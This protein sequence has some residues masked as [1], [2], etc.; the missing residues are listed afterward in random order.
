MTKYLQTNEQ[1]YVVGITSEELLT[2]L[3][4]GSQRNFRRL[5]DQE[6][7]D[8]QVLLKAHHERGEGLHIDEMVQ[9]KK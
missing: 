9:F 5:S 7:E 8:V 1:G 6:A 4:G 2:G 3:F